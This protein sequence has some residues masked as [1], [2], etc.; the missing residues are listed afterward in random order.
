MTVNNNVLD[1]RCSQLAR[2][3]S[4][5]DKTHSGQL[6]VWLTESKSNPDIPDNWMW[7]KAAPSFY[8]VTSAGPNKAKSTDCPKSYGS[9]PVPTPGNYVVVNFM[10]GDVGKGFWTNCAVHDVGQTRMMPDT[11]EQHPSTAAPSPDI[12]PRPPNGDYLARAAHQGI[13]DDPLRGCGTASLHRD[14]SP[15]CQT[16]TTPGGTQITMDDKEGSS[17]LRFRT[18]SGV[19]LLLSET[20][21][22]IYAITKDGKSWFEFN[23]DGNVDI[24]AAL[25][26]NIHAANFINMS[27]DSSI[28]IKTKALSIETDSFI[29]KSTN[30]DI[31]A[32]AGLYLSGMGSINSFSGGDH[33][34]T[35]G[36]INLRGGTIV[37]S[38]II[39][40]ITDAVLAETMGAAVSQTPPM[41]G[42]SGI[43][44]EFPSRVPTAEPFQGRQVKGSK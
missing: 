34:I 27:A 33:N 37:S 19:Q 25:S 42:T 30:T 35:G 1:L 15:Q 13:G 43:A 7:V 24:Y 26:V 12:N 9:I 4:N 11:P 16:I 8:G 21:G 22:H 39:G 44:L 2:V 41:A 14:D 18:K 31:Q 6:L 40:K 36:T 5:A 38:D 20:E 10:N 3:I 17:L 29:S 32:G 28:R 23:N